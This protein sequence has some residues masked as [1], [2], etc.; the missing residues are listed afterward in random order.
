MS[1]LIIMGILSAILALLSITPSSAEGQFAW[2][3][4]GR[5]G[6]RMDSTPVNSLDNAGVARNPGF[7]SIV[8]NCIYNQKRKQKMVEMSSMLHAWAISTL[9]MISNINLAFGDLVV[10]NAWVKPAFFF[11][12]DWWNAIYG[13]TMD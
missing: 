9:R 3:P 1:K 8:C 12:P 5:F 2:R 11:D 10:H 4:Q 13:G 6:K 7:W